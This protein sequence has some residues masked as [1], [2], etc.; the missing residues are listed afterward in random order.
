M[1]TRVNPFRKNN[2]PIWDTP[3][4][5]IQEEIDGIRG[6]D[7]ESTLAARQ[8]YAKESYERDKAE[9]ERLRIRVEYFEKHFK[10]FLPEETRKELERN[11]SFKMKT[12]KGNKICAAVLKKNPCIEPILN[13]NRSQV[14]PFNHPI[15]EEY[16]G[17]A[18]H[19]HERAI[20]KKKV[21]MESR[22]MLLWVAGDYF[23]KA[24]NIC[25][26]KMVQKI[27]AKFCNY[28]ILIKLGRWHHEGV[29]GN[30]YAVGYWDEDVPTTK[31]NKKGEVV[32]R[33]IYDLL[34]RYFYNADKFMALLK[35][36]E[37]G[38]R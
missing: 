13:F 33:K 30:L 28:E 36:L 34:P 32:S 37:N 23:K 5:S 29:L 24:E 18:K 17:I 10:A 26:Q 4:P 31:K 16:S 20:N 19:V 3:I 27:N 12:V 25:S 22:F 14:L 2:Q 38:W 8:A 11:R 35:G 1:I 15:T 7:E 6:V 9:L 21:K